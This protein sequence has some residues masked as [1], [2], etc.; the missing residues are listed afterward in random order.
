NNNKKNYIMSASNSQSEDYIVEVKTEGKE[1]KP[2]KYLAISP[3]GDFLVVLVIKNLVDLEFE[4]Q[5]YHIQ[6]SNNKDNLTLE[7]VSEQIDGLKPESSSEP[8]DDQGLSYRKLSRIPTTFKFTDKQLNMNIDEYENIFRWFVAVSD[9]SASSSEF[10]LLAISCVNIKDVT[11]YMEN[12]SKIHPMEIRNNGFTFDYIIDQKTEN[13]DEETDKRSQN[14]DEHL[15]ILL[16]LSGIYKYHMKNKSISNI[17][18]LKYP[19]RIYNAIKNNLNLPFEI[20]SI[21]LVY[22]II[23]VFIKHSLNKH[24]FLVDTMKENI[25]YVELY[26]LK[27][28]QLVNTFRRPIYYKSVMIDIPNCYAVSNNGKLLAYEYESNKV[29]KIYSIECSLEIA[30]LVITN[31]EFV[32]VTFIEFFH[33]DEMLLVYSSKNEWSIWNIFGSLRDSIKLGDPGFKIELPPVSDFQLFWEIE[34]SNSFMVVNKSDTLAIYDD[35]IV[36]KHLKYLKKSDKQDWKNLSKDYFLRQDLD[37]NI[38]DL[39]DKESELDEDNYML[40]PW[41]LTSDLTAPQYS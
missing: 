38:R 30:E 36:D 22:K 13:D 27:T 14:A 25:K 7:N 24:Y 21:D 40:E 19:K 34:R 26:N 17:Q 20:F 32:N 37:K 33:N 29:I 6:N 41:L 10:R 18:K 8:E 2:T 28:N 3:E 4:F 5:L 9:K 15:L 16:T 31:S 23:L 1:E 12:S 11:G 39:H 35:L